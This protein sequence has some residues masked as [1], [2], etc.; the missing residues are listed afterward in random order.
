[1]VEQS[2][3]PTRFRPNRGNAQA[4]DWG[5][6]FVGWGA[7]GRFSEF[8]AD[9]NLL[10]DATVPTTGGWDDYRA[11]RFVWHGTP[12]TSPTATVQKNAD[13]SVTVHAIWNGATEVSR[14]I[15]IGAST[16]RPS[17]RS[18]KPNGTASTPPSRSGA[19]LSM[20]PWWPRTPTVD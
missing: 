2:S 9:G 11:Y 13:G 17:G 16:P 15:V 4:L 8:D 18:A 14:W 10:F 1:M 3:T 5:H 12:D 20:S 19:T 6:T 7:T